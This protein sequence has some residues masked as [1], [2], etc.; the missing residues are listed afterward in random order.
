MEKSTTK[1]DLLETVAANYKK[2]KEKG[3]TT[4]PTTKADLLEKAVRNYNKMNELI[5]GLSEE[6]LSTSFDFTSDSGK[7]EN[8]IIEDK[9]Y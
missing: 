8:I 5:S 9:I 2:M 3:S 7:K 4:R 1:S 6:E